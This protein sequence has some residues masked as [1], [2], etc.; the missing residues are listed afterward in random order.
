MRPILRKD[1]A[2]PRVATTT[3]VYSPPFNLRDT[4]EWA[5]A[6]D[7]YSAPGYFSSA[8]RANLSQAL[9]FDGTHAFGPIGSQVGTRSAMMPSG[10]PNFGFVHTAYE[11]LSPT[12]SVKDCVHNRS[13]S[14]EITEP[15]PSVR[16]A[17]PEWFVCRG[18][19]P[20]FRDVPLLSPLSP[21]FTDVI[22]PCT[23]EAASHPYSSHMCWSAP[24]VYQ[25]LADGVRRVIRADKSARYIAV[26]EMD[27]YAIPCPA[28]MKLVQEERSFSG[29][30]I[31]A[32]SNVAKMVAKEYSGV[33]IETIAY[34]KPESLIP[35]KKMKKL[36]HNVA[37]R[38]CDAAKV[39]S[40]GYD[41]PVNNQSLAYL[42][43]WIN[44]SSEVSIWTYM[45]NID[46]PLAPYPNY[47]QVAIDIEFLAREGAAGYFA[48]GAAQPASDMTEL[49]AYLI[50]RKTFEPLLNTNL[51]VDEFVEGY[52]G[53]E[54][55]PFVRTYLDVLE[56]AAS[57]SPGFGVGG[58]GVPPS[59]ALF[60]NETVLA[61]AWAL[62]NATAAAAGS[63][64]TKYHE[65]TLRAA[66]PI[67]YI[68]LLR[69]AEYRAFCVEMADCSWPAQGTKRAAFEEF[70]QVSTRAGVRLV[71]IPS[72]PSWRV[73][74]CW[75]REANATGFEAWLFPQ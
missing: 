17:H 50:G 55:A 26:D 6:Q 5:V 20:Q 44:L 69:W 65:R 47:R 28:D 45:G 42:R 74:D 61:A 12:G 10:K 18:W 32:V 13:W 31:H 11:L 59:S 3:T 58:G 8:A 53:V 38:L 16:K 54:A 1:G 34:H 75:N 60:G 27:G 2:I 62:R 30:L 49:K 25:A 63:R 4:T 71:A 48:Q 23:A 9:G 37:V 70:A 22:Y 7:H 68:L 36:P 46:W 15:C 35:P 33:K 24:G 73:T 51:L 41:A 57:L 14:T 72:C 39:Q 29:P 56:T 21:N 52:F 67:R 66:L 64:V 43:G 19:P 40:L